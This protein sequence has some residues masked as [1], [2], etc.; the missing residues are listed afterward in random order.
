[1]KCK[2]LKPDNIRCSANAMV[3]FEH[4]FS[5]NPETQDKKKSAVLKGGLSPKP[6]KSA[7]PLQFVALKSVSDVLLLLEDTINRVRTDPITH[8]KANCVGYLANIALKA[9]EVGNLEERLSA[10]EEKIKITPN[11]TIKSS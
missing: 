7:E 2:F 1:M 6:R 4:C 10:L 8:Q 3:G 9:L 5:H 11:E